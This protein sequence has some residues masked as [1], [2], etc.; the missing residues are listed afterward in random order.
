[1]AASGLALI[2]V[3][4]H[5]MQSSGNWRSFSITPS[6]KWIGTVTTTKPASLSSSSALSQSWL[7]STLT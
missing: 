1:M 4:S 5:K 3:R 6:V 2:E 7:P